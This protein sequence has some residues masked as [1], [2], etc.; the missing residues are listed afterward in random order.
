M[1]F[2]D[3]VQRH[4]AGSLPEKHF[5]RRAAVTLIQQHGFTPTN[6]LAC[7]GVCRDELCRSLFNSEDP[8]L[9][10]R[11]STNRIGIRV[12]RF[13]RLRTHGEQSRDKFTIG[14]DPITPSGID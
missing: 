5:V 8:A 2:E 11:R 14:S 9:N 1:S 3:L 4:F 10:E 7:V 6:T 12:Q 13:R